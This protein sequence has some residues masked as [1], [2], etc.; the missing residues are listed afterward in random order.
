MSL[1]ITS[2]IGVDD[3]ETSNVFKPFSYQNALSNTM[4]IP[5]NS[6]IALESAKINK[7]SLMVVDRTNTG[8]GFY[9]GKPL[10][11]EETIL[12]SATTP[13]RGIGGVGEA[14]REGK[15]TSRNTEDF[16]SDLEASLKE[17]A[18]HPTLISEVGGVVD[19][20]VDVAAVFPNNQFKGY[21]WTITQQTGITKKLGTS[22][23]EGS[24]TDIS[25]DTNNQFK[26]VDG[27]I[28]STAADGSTA[29]STNNGFCCQNREHPIAQNE[30]E[31]LV[32]FS[33]ANSTGPQSP[34]SIG[35]TRINTGK[36]IMGAE[37]FTPKNFA[38]DSG[39]G[40]GQAKQHFRRG[41]TSEVGAFFDICITR[42]GRSLFVY[43]SGTNANGDL[44]MNEVVYYGAWNKNFG[45]QLDLSATMSNAKYTK[46]K[47][48][49]V[50]EEMKIF[51]V[52]AGG[53]VLLCD[54]TVMRGTS[55]G[56]TAAP[57]NSFINP[58]NCAKWAL[59]PQIW[60]IPRGAVKTFTIDYIQH[61]TNYPKYTDN[62]YSDYD[63]WGFCE[64]QSQESQAL[65]VESRPWNDR[66]KTNVLTDILVPVGVDASGFM[67]GYVPTLITAK[68]DQYG[69]V[70]TAGCNSQ[71]AFGFLGRP[72]TVASSAAAAQPIT[73]ESELVPTLSS[74]ASLFVRLN[75]FTQNSVN[76]RQGTLSKIVAHL[77]RFD[78]SGNDTGALYFSPNT[79][80][81]LDLNNSEDILVNSFDVDIVY[82]NETFCTA[83]NGKTIVCF[84]I[85]QKKP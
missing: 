19:P 41:C 9:F 77:P 65:E 36:S 62:R 75:N 82:D 68:S 66:S 8:Y 2:N 47:F 54:F 55:D 33:A 39:G 52:N 49:L 57:K 85:R 38:L 46:V 69:A 50:G 48:K 32:D 18:Y 16:A 4:R 58:M 12:K 44:C 70:Q 17:I 5:K 74:G 11:D 37:V 84:H 6:E 26:I 31:L 29:S 53:D 43:Q 61:Y 3:V 45:T 22:M 81:Y 79:P 34:F 24:W 64:E 80:V 21:K 28:S 25:D 42:A 20:T 13:F 78:N 51:L 40:A 83:L 59:Y 7:N 73:I 27:V 1:I 63:W 14:F 35:L 60:T 72:I 67:D 10:A 15:R 76:A 71:N 23:K 56:T 30:G